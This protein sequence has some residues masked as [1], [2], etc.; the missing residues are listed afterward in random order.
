MQCLDCAC[1]RP[2]L[3]KKSLKRKSQMLGARLCGQPPILQQADGEPRHSSNKNILNVKEVQ[4][5]SEAAM[6]IS[7][8]KL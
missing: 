8:Q 1:Y 5:K 7:N 2:L 4:G 6:V 3:G